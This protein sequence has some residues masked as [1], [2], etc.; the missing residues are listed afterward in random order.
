MLAFA[1]D[2]VCYSKMYLTAVVILYANILM[3]PSPRTYRTGGNGLNPK[4]LDA[5]LLGR[6]SGQYMSHV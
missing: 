2:S 5:S 6:P 4:A 1:P 3:T